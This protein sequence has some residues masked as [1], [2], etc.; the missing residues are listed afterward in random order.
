MTQNNCKIIGLTGSIGTGKSTVTEILIQEGYVIIDA[1]KIAREVVEIGKPAYNSIVEVFGRRILLVDKTINRKKLGR[2]IFS[3][4]S[5]RNVL[6]DIV[7][8]YII[9]EIKNQI[10]HNCKTH[11]II[12]A[13]IPLLIEGIDRF[14]ANKVEFDEIWLVYADE[15]TQIKRLMERDILTRAEALNKINSQMNIEDKKSKVTKIIDN[16]GDFT[17]LKANLDNMLRELQ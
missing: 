4:N 14:Q 11:K 3:S 13:D 6:N 1:D 16:S 12:F 2:L 5:L 7:H 9:K 15:E 8:P 10:D 17:T